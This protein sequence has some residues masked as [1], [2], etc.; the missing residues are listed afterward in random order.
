MSFRKNSAQQISL[1][2]SFSSLTQREQKVLEKSWAKTFADDVFPAINE[3]R[4]SVLYSDKASRPN[5]PVNVIIGALVLK[6]LFDLS[7]D[8][9]V[10]NLI[11]DPR[12]QYALHTTSFDE[13]PISD[14]TLTRFRQR[15]YDYEQL[16][17][18]DLY[19]DCVT[20][21]GRLTAKLI[22][23]DGRIRRMDSLMV[24][25]NIRKLSR[26]ELVYRCI[27]R[28]VSYL[29]KNGHDNLLEGLEHYY[30]PDD[31]NRVIYHSR[32]T[33][34]DS[35]MQVL[36]QD[37]GTL[38]ERCSGRFDEVT[39]YQL[40]VRCTSE[41]T[42]EEGGARR[43]RTKEDGQMGS[44]IL[45]SPADPDAT[46]REKAGESHRG[47]AA[48]VEESV[49]E[50]GSAI[51]DYQFET[52]NTSD[53]AMLKEKLNSMEK[54]EKPV[55]VVTDGAFAGEENTQLAAEKN[56]TLI[57]TD[58][59]GK[60]V[61]PII[62]SFVLNE[63]ETRVLQCPMGHAPVSSSYIRQTGTC[64]ASFNRECCANCPHRKDC[65][66]KIFKR[67]AKIRVTRKQVR[68]AILQEKMKAE[69]YKLFARF[70]NGVET[71]P[72][73]LKNVYN[74]NKMPVRGKI[75]CKFFF[76]S[77][78][79]ALNFKKLLGFRRGTGKYAQNALLTAGC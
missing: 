60:D 22:G 39:E 6:E 53:S 52:N 2:D 58:L 21:L 12:F 71:L 27:S 7:D 55:T 56:V 23:I 41:Q 54:Q 43:L 11:L 36:L 73:I 24:E 37:I 44:D 26:M 62:G 61:S 46:Y 42:V 79:A 28:L 10:E 76:G 5:T 40:L 16:H 18:I 9:V 45:Q 57:T 34:T 51:T 48:N 74:V 50:N 14:K 32:S 64:T 1:F 77:K 15:C 49:S 17:G 78:V 63:E 75:H 59:P 67:V 3:E 25:S 65:N 19:H 20:D 33:E 35:R 38:L 47:Y 69:D 4:F 31:F 70:R 13:Q 66:A 8:E 30:D 29:H 72:S 68:R